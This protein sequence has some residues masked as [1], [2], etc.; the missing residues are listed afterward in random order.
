METE[1]ADR[2]RCEV[3]HQSG[4]W[5]EDDE[6]CY[7]CGVEPGESHKAGCDIARC[8]ITGEQR[9]SCSDDHDCG[10][11]VWTGLWPGEAECVEFGWW[12]K[13]IDGPDGRGHWEQ[14]TADDPDREPD[15]NG[16]HTGETVWD[17][18][19]GRWVLRGEA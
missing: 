6:A 7:D 2:H 5:D 12:S 19:A 16:L 9:L 18:K 8:L 11:D 3:E 4:M 13:W 17:R 1:I 14:T 15:L 10:S